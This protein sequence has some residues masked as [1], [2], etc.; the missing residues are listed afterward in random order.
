MYRVE[1]QLNYKGQ[2][3]L[4]KAGLSDLS[5][6]RKEGSRHFCPIGQD[7]G[8]AASV[9]LGQVST[10]HWDLTLP[11]VSPPVGRRGCGTEGIRASL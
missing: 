4:S 6:D 1:R 9:A 11:P 7:L 2:S 5:E 10:Q 8:S 3:F